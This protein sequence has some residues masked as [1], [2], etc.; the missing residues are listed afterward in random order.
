MGPC[1][2]LRRRAHS[3]SLPRRALLG[4]PGQGRFT[5]SVAGCPHKLCTGERSG[6]QRAPAWEP[7]MLRLQ[8]RCG[9]LTLTHASPST[10]PSTLSNASKNA[11]EPPQQQQVTHV[12]VR[13]HPMAAPRHRSGLRPRRAR[14]LAQGRVRA[15]LNT[16]RQ[17]GPC[18][19]EPPSARA[20]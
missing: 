5:T 3:R 11:R 6:E 17:G 16:V 8:T 19:F 12:Q 7:R 1:A 18:R 2:G 4:L 13:A 20:R 15:P 10:P 9:T 14:V